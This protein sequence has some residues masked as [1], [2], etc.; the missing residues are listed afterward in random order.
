LQ[1]SILPILTFPTY[2]VGG[3]SPKNFV[4]LTAYW[5]NTSAN[6]NF[7]FAHSENFVIETVL[8]KKK[9]PNIRNLNK[10][11]ESFI[12]KGLPNSYLAARHYWHRKE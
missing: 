11:A 4:A 9:G 5:A 8:I 10:I 3:A 6:V 2:L 7:F 12:G 1:N